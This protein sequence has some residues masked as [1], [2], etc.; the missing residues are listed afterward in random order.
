VPESTADEGAAV[1]N[2]AEVDVVTAADEAVAG[3]EPDGVA[4][5]EDE[6]AAADVIP[7]EDRAEETA[8]ATTVLQIAGYSP[9]DQASGQLVGWPPCQAPGY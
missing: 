2:E 1:A 6:R 4:A 8:D 3:I 7:A 9:V 5:T